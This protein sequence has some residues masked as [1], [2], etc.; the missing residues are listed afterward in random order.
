MQ[1]TIFYKNIINQFSPGEMI[2]QQTLT[3]D[4]Y[5]FPASTE[6]VISTTCALTDASQ[7]QTAYQTLEVT[8]NL[9]QYAVF[10]L[11]AFVD[12]KNLDPVPFPD[13]S[14][15]DSET[16]VN[17]KL[18]EISVQYPRIL[19]ELILQ[20]P[21]NANTVLARLFLQNKRPGYY[22][23]LMRFLTAKPQF[24][25]NPNTAIVARVR[26]IGYGP[27]GADDLV[28]FYGEVQEIGIYSDPPILYV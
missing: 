2:G 9:T 25:G 12:I 26:D 18:N 24:L 21:P 7:T 6:R 5:R 4:L 8:H 19:F 10:S 14:I 23:D 20:E 3:K 11:R 22:I 17:Q 13:I 1:E 28:T 27:L 16:V 15:T